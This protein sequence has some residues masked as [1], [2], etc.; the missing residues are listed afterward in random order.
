MYEQS[1][2]ANNRIGKPVGGK[3]VGR[4]FSRGRALRES[5]QQFF[6]S[7][8]RTR[9]RV[10]VAYMVKRREF[11]MPRGLAPPCQML[12]THMVSGF[13]DSLLVEMGFAQRLLLLVRV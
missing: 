1:C 3:D 2:V 7:R 4:N 5:S 12:P 8:G 11:R 10:L 6:I 13:I 9:H